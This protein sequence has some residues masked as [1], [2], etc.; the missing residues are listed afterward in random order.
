MTDND[1]RD[2]LAAEYVLGTLDLE[3]RAQALRLVASDETCP[4]IEDQSTDGVRGLGLSPARKS[5]IKMRQNFGPT[6]VE[7]AQNP[8]IHDGARERQVPC[9]LDTL[10]FSMRTPMEVNALGG[11]RSREIGQRF[12]DG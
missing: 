10:R 12:V 6:F 7:K 8:P 9:E 3:E 1:D 11:Y 2:V 5:R 4:R